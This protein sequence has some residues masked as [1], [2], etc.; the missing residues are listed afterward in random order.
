MKQDIKMLVDT[1]RKRSYSEHPN[2]E[3]P[4]CKMSH[5]RNVPH[6]KRLTNELSHLRNASP[7]KH[8]TYEKC[9]PWTSQ[10][11]QR[12]TNNDVTHDKISL[13]V[14]LQKRPTRENITKCLN[15]QSFSTNVRLNCLRRL[16]EGRFLYSRGC[17]NKKKTIL[18]HMT[19]LSYQDVK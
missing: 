9:H 18:L 8:S 3:R 16:V 4:K 12:T 14:P 19:K 15:H 1:L 10:A 13:N 17:L 2:T 7:T 5:Q 11:I 6:T